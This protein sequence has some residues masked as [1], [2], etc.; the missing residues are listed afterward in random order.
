MNIDRDK[1]SRLGISMQDIGDTLA[2]MLG[3]ADISRFSMQGRSYKVIPQA[4][5][6]F[7]LTKEWL[8]RYYLRTSGGELVALST[9][10]EWA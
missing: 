6:D 1:A 4:S 10:I 5:R 7:R 2:I 9:V 3:E 8:Q